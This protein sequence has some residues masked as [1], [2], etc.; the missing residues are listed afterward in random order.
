MSDTT[1]IYLASPLGSQMFTLQEWRELL[2][3]ARDYGWEPGGTEPPPGRDELSW[4][5]SYVPAYGQVMN[6]ADAAQFADALDKA[7][8]DIPSE[9]NRPLTAPATVTSVGL[10]V[11]ERYRGARLAI[12]QRLARNAH[13]GEIRLQPTG[14]FDVDAPA[15]LPSP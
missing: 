14:R 15:P 1:Y 4:D 13:A 8:V 7:A 11:L 12:L 3:L 9:A 6:A 10:T 5:R 2:Q